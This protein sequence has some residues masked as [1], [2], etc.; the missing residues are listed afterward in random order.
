M[1]DPYLVTSSAGVPKGC[2]VGKEPAYDLARLQDMNQMTRRGSNWHNYVDNQDNGD[3]TADYSDG[4]LNCLALRKLGP[5]WRGG[6]IWSVHASLC[7]TDGAAVQPAD[8][9]AML[10]SLKIRV[11]DPV[12]NI[13]PADQSI[14]DMT[15]EGSYQ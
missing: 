14:R 2:H 5:N 3:R 11:Y 12:G 9:H 15:A 6:V 4:R 8:V 7:R 10:S 1:F 13:R